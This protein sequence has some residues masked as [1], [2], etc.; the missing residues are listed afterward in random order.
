MD[1]TAKDKVLQQLVKEITKG[2]PE[3]K[4]KLDERLKPFWNNRLKLTVADGIVM[5][6]DRV[7]VPKEMQQGVLEELH[8]AHQGQE[9]AMQRAR[10]MVYW[11][12]MT[13]DVRNV[14]KTC[15]E[16]QVYQPSQQREPLLQ[17]P[18][19]TRPGK[20]ITVDFF[21]CEGREYLVI[22]DKYSG[23]PEIYDFTRGVSTQF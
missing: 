2:F 6:N 17:D 15:E 1:T 3:E 8:A 14:V 11:P 20:A 9:R 19:P 22:T 13:N 21:S 12:G 16:C 10:Q 18:Q 4:T 7:V 5:C 23:W